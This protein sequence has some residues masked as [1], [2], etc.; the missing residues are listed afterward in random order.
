MTEQLN[1]GARQL[2]ID[3]VYDPEGGRYATPLGRKMAPNTTAYDLS[4]MGKPGMKVIHAPDL[5]YRTVCQ[6]F[7]ACLQENPR[8]VQ[9]APGSR[10]DPDHLQP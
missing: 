9:G 10:A 6:P 2:E 4:A 5:D 1:D 8:L 7:T 3:F